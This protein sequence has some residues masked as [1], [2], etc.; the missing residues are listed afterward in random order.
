MRTHE[1]KIAESMRPG[2]V[3]RR[4]SGL[5][6]SF[7]LVGALGPRDRESLKTLWALLDDDE[8]EHLIQWCKENKGKL[9]D[10]VQVRL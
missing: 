2:S 8:Q 7:N 9:P 10:F 5:I 1:E 4:A 6:A 3:F